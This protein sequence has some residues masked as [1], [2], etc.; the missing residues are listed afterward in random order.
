MSFGL[1]L[2]YY[3]KQKKLSQDELSKFAKISPSAI[4]QYE[5]GGREPSLSNLIKLANAF[6]ITIDDLL[7]KK[8]KEPKIYKFIASIDYIKDN[9]IQ[10]E[11]QEH[12]A[13]DIMEDDKTILYEIIMRELLNV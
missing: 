13:L 11:A 8:I 2:K 7:N 9:F 12:D 1:K 5:R 3:R 10:L 4:C 6:K